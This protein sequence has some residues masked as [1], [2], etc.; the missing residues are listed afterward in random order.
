[1]KPEISETELSILEYLWTENEPRSFSQIMTHFNTVGQKDW[2]KQTVNT[3]LLR[4]TKK[5]F[6]KPDKSAVKTLY[7]PTITSEEYYQNFTQKIIDHSFGG[8][9][10][11]F[12]SAFTGNQKL[13]AEE[14]AELLDYIEKL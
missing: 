3:F 5:G 4:L 10:M 7:Y 1:M 9:I 12:V 6:L 8:S 13:S 2:K 14:K 11:N